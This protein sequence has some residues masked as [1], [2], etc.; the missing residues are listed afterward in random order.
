MS[1]LWIRA[2]A[3][4]TG[5]RW[6][7]WDGAALVAD[8]PGSAGRALLES[9]GTDKPS[10]G[11][12][13][14]GGDWLVALTGYR[15]SQRR[16]N[17]PRATAGFVM[18]GGEREC[19]DLAA[20]LAADID[21]GAADGLG[22]RLAQ[23]VTDGADTKTVGVQGDPMALIRGAAA[24]PAT[25]LTGAGPLAEPV[26]V[27]APDA[28]AATR[29][30]AE[31]AGWEEPAAAPP[32]RTLPASPVRS[33]H[34]VAGMVNALALA[35]VVVTAILFVLAARALVD[36]AD[37]AR[38]A[39]G[40]D[41]PASGIDVFQLVVLLLVGI[42][43]VL[44]LWFAVSHLGRRV[45]ARLAERH[46]SSRGAQ[47]F[48]SRR[49][50]D[51]RTWLSELLRSPHWRTRAEAWDLLP[52][53]GAKLSDEEYRRAAERVQ[54]E[55]EREVGGVALATGLAAAIGRGRLADA[56]VVVAG[57][58]GLQIETLASLGLRPSARAWLRLGAAASTGVLAG[59]YVDVEERYEV[60]LAVRGAAMGIDAT[61]E[62]LEG[63]EDIVS[64]FLG[65]ALESAGA[66]G[67]ALGT[68]TGGVIGLTGSALRQLS[69]F[70]TE[71]GD[72]VTEG[73][74]IAALLHHHGMS[75]VADA[76]GLDAEHRAELAPAAGRIPRALTE[77][78]T[79]LAR[80]QTRAFRRLLQQRTRA[81]YRSA[82]Q[83][84]KDRIL[85]R[86][87]APRES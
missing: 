71:V 3:V 78:G 16:T 74:V 4:L 57:S 34:L 49:D 12:S 18:A 86:G 68:A 54:A 51:R 47:R 32:E 14:A 19:R 46:G 50:W 13:G 64:D 24:P 39:L 27:T 21:R 67:A 25:P 28:P 9:L 73:I 31:H 63:A 35:G 58:A 17:T 38:T 26:V 8:E 56:V 69:D 22:A 2:R 85:Q 43:P 30:A 53:G 7:R 65:D 81:A 42:G 15:T 84:V 82:P 1:V 83:S 60:K 75:L 48:S 29:P 10:V 59:S 62:M 52:A 70:V 11:L 45:D 40:F 87:G 77:G 72:E 5:E 80:R 66:F 20:A 55:L 41:P 76:L 23:L 36:L 79:L 33:P 6:W 37:E 61:G 44:L